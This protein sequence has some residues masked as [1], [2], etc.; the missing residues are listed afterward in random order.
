MV[1]FCVEKGNNTIT[2]SFKKVYLPQVPGLEIVKH[3]AGLGEQSIP[4]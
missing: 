1:L 4:S 3:S 2:L